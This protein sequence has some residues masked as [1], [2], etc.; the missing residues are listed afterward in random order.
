MNNKVIV[1]YYGGMIQTGIAVVFALRV[2][3]IGHW[4]FWAVCVASAIVT[5]VAAHAIAREA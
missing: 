2:R 3:G 4:S 5:M 1:G